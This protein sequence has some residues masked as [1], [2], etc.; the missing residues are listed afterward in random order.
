MIGSRDRSNFFCP[1]STSCA[2]LSV[3][4]FSVVICIVAVSIYLYAAYVF[5]AM[6]DFRP[7]LSI[8]RRQS[9]HLSNKFFCFQIFARFYILSVVGQEDIKNEIDGYTCALFDLFICLAG[10]TPEIS[11]PK[12]PATGRTITFWASGPSSANCCL[13]SSQIT[14]RL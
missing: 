8:R 4:C 11:T 5:P 14:D 7:F 12:G 10:T 2:E 1:T 6:P 3:L 13:I 9:N